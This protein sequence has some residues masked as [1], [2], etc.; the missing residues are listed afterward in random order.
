M[1][2]NYVKNKLEQ[3]RREGYG[4]HLEAV[5]S[6]AFD[7][8]KKSI[9][10]GFVATFVYMVLMVVMWFSMFGTLYGMSLSEFAEMAQRNPEALETSMANISTTSM[11]IYSL[12]GGLVGALIAPMLSG[13]YKVAFNTKYGGNGSISDLSAYYKSP[14]FLNI[15]LYSF[16]FAVVMQLIN[17]GL[18]KALPGIG[19]LLGILVMVLLSVTFVFTIPF[20]VFGQLSWTEAIKASITVTSK[21]W[22][23]LFFILLISFIISLIGVI[24]CGIGVLLTYPFLYIA[25]FVLYDTII[26]FQGSEDSIEKIGEE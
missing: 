6:D 4:L 12:V 3:I 17:F 1:E 5:L 23:F 16:L 9:L 26:G 15:F 13:L 24:F 18:D 25:T 21:N 19:S 22:F 8:H 11:L 2:S 10:P 7:I 14:Y 20:I